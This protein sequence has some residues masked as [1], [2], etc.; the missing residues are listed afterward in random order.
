MGEEALPGQQRLAERTFPFDELREMRRDRHVDVATEPGA[1][2]LVPFLL[3][4]DETGRTENGR[5]NQPLSERLWAK[6]EF[7]IDKPAVRWA[8]L[9]FIRGSDKTQ[10]RFNG[11]RLSVGPPER[12]PSGDWGVVDVP[13]ECLREGLNEVVF[14]GSGTLFVENN[15]WPNRSAR[16]VDGGKTWDYDHIGGD[17][18]F[19]GEYTVR[20]GLG[21]YP[22]GGAIWSDGIEIAALAAGGPIRPRV[23][24][25]AVCLMANLTAPPGTEVGF[26]LRSGMTPEYDPE[27]WEAWRPAPLGEWLEVPPGHGYLQWRAALSTADPLRTPLL[28]SVTLRA[29]LEAHRSPDEGKIRVVSFKNQGIIRSSYH[30]VYQKPGLRLEILREK[31]HL[32]DLVAGAET[33]VERFAALRHWTRHQ[34]D[35][36]WVGG[37]YA[38]CAPMDALVVLDMAKRGKCA[39]FCGHYAAV[40]VQCALALGYTGRDVYLCT[41]ACAEVWSNQYGKWIIMDPGPDQDDEKRI[42]YHYE[43]RGVPM[44]SLELHERLTEGDWEGLEAVTSNPSNHWEPARDPDAMQR[45]LY[46]RIPFRNNMLDSPLPGDLDVRGYPSTTDWIVWRDGA[47]S[48]LRR[49]YP[50]STNRKGDIYWTLNQ[51]AIYPSYG[52]RTGWLRLEFDT[53]T[54]NLR[55][56]QVRLDGAGWTPCGS[57]FD[58]QLHKGRNLLEA[59]TLNAFDIPGIVSSLEV[60]Y[61]G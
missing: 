5:F 48:E 14:S 55:T 45:Y 35:N 11:R 47:V 54:P 4:F 33:E 8:Q 61:A 19:N 3:L 22:D 30:F 36:G 42:N 40:F 44:N 20:L 21:R 7:V 9:Y 43:C 28:R 6:K 59:R 41:H 53:Q 38:F 25:E 58:W 10:I 27:A 26:E 51:V 17:G 37:E 49:D 2:S 52:D 32:D 29:K 13:V 39:A 12:W 18:A 1:I 23:R 50:Y 56:Y 24:A 34:W 46:V 57:T 15:L 60:S 16:S 31:Y